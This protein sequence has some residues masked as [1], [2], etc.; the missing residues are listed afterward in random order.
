MRGW[1]NK[2]AYYFS[3]FCCYALWLFFLAPK[4]C[5]CGC[6]S[7]AKHFLILWCRADSPTITYESVFAVLA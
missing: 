3:A 2:N 5:P 1:L 6:C 7:F 4:Q